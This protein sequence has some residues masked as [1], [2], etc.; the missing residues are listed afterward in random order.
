M[1]LLF[2][3][4]GS[5]ILPI[6]TLVMN[7]LSI[8]AAFGLLVL[9]FQDGFG[10][11]LFAYSP[12]GDRDRRCSVI[13]CATTFGLSTDYAVLVLA[14]IKEFHDRGQGQRD[15]R[16]RWA[17]SAPAGSSRPPR[18]CSRRLPRVHDRRSS[19]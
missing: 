15:R 14:R 12:T 6:K 8:G 3:L 17:S 10:A 19:S 9:L 2:L 1:I 7:M 13:V 5:V 16:A 18:C 4:T 11:D